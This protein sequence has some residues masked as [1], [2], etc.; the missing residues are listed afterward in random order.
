MAATFATP[1]HSMARATAAVRLSVRLTLVCAA[2]LC[3]TPA[4][5]R[6]QRAPIPAAPA[7]PAPDAPKDP[8]GRTTPR[9]T[10][11]GFLIAAQKGE[12]A[13]AREF[14]N[15]RLTG[16]D[17]DTLAQQLFAV[18]DER[19]PARLTQLSD[20]PEGSKANP[21]QPNQEVI[22]TIESSQGRVDVVLERVNNPKTGS[23]WLFSRRT[24]DAVPA[25]YADVVQSQSTSLFGR[26][27]TGT[28][29]G[30]VR[31][32]QWIAVLFA[33][34][35]SYIITVFLNRLLTP[36]ILRLWNRTFGRVLPWRGQVL[37]APL[38]LLILALV[39]RWVLSH[40]SLSLFVREFWSNA[41]SIV[42]IASSAWLVI[43]L[44]GE[45]EDYLLR[46]SVRSAASARSSLLRLARRAADV[47][48]LFVALLAMLH[49]FA[50]DV[51]PALAG[52]GVGGIAVAL[53][54]QKTLENVIAGVSL[55]FDQ[56]IRVGDT[57]KTGTVVGT[58]DDIGLRSTRIRTGD[59]TV[60]SIPN[61]QLATANL[62]TLSARDKFPFQ[63]VVGVRYETTPDQLRE[64]IDGIRQLL[65]AQ[66][67]IE[68][69]SSR[70]R[71]IRL[72]AFSLDVEVFAYLL[73]RDWNHFLEIQEGLLFAITGIVAAAGTEIAFPSQTMYVA[74]TPATVPGTVPPR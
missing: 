49:L 10:V 70:V 41:A 31:L 72:G 54:A 33:I 59:R 28:Q 52:L 13:L 14:L 67:L 19:L 21:L 24:L 4:V 1:D 68:A 18:L 9:G 74:N 2:T 71:F 61:G 39:G 36:A 48:V 29:I 26:L 34:I 12:T 53:A 63:H 60:V 55:I 46:H 44:N 73:A 3:L 16:A 35:V 32:F 30:G 57:L 43:I 17:A 58:V 64:I 23:V 11:L 45:L 15:T 69:D 42:T 5:V 66:P 51:T 22:G 37:P 65:L 6:A 8:L 62:E 50:V 56:A 38:R 25:L 7:A 40:V 20:E 47:V 27:L